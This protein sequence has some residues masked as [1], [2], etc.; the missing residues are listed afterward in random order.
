MSGTYMVRRWTIFFNA[1]LYLQADSTHPLTKH[2]KIASSFR[3]SSLF[4]I[5]TL[6]CNLLKQVRDKLVM[7]CFVYPKESCSMLRFT[8]KYMRL[9]VLLC[10]YLGIWQELESKRWEPARAAHAA[11]QTGP[12]LPQLWLHRYIHRW[13]LRRSVHRPDPHQLEIRWAACS[14]RWCSSNLVFKTCVYFRY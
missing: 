14:L 7:V 11:P 8:G 9:S 2:R 1:F 4:D 12:Q 10:V 13:V 6:S 5:F 3:D